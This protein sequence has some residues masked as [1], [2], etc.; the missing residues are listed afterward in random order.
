MTV[1]IIKKTLLTLTILFIVVNVKAQ[2]QKFDEGFIQV[3]KEMQIINPLLFENK[4]VAKPISIVPWKQKE[5]LTI[6]KGRLIK[7]FAYE[8][9]ASI[10]YIYFVFIQNEIGDN[11]IEVYEV[12]YADQKP[13]MVFSFTTKNEDAESWSAYSDNEVIIKDGYLYFESVSTDDSGYYY[14]FKYKLGEKSKV[15]DARYLEGYIDTFYRIDNHTHTA[16]AEA[17]NGELSI[18]SSETDLPEIEFVTKG[19]ENGFYIGNLS[20]SLDDKILYFDNFASGLA[21]IWRYNTESKELSKIVPEHEAEHPFAFTYNYKEYIFYIEENTIKI[22]TSNMK[23]SVPIKTD[24]IGVYE[25]SKIQTLVTNDFEIAEIK[26]SSDRAYTY[27]TGTTQ[28]NSHGT[29]VFSVFLIENMSKI[30]SKI[31][32]EI[33][34]LR[35]YTK[36]RLSNNINIDTIDEAMKIPIGEGDCCYKDNIILFF[37]KKDKLIKGLQIRS[38]HDEE[39][40]YETRKNITPNNLSNQIWIENTVGHTGY[41]DNSKHNYFTNVEKYKFQND[42]L[43]LIS[44]KTIDDYYHVT[45][46][47]GLN[48]HNRPYFSGEK[49]KVLD[50]GAKVKLLNKTD[51]THELWDGSKLVKGNWV[52]IEIDSNNEKFAAYVFDGYLNKEL[53]NVNTN[54]ETTIANGEWRW[55]YDTEQL[56]ELGFYKNGK[57]DG[58]WKWFFKNGTLKAIGSYKDG[59]PNG[60]RKWYYGNNKL[61]CTG[62]FS[63]GGKD[64][65]WIWYSN[66]KPRLSINFDKGNVVEFKI[67]D[68]QEKVILKT[69]NTSASKVAFSESYDYRDVFEVRIENPDDYNLYFGGYYMSFWKSKNNI[70]SGESKSYKNGKLKRITHYKAGLKTGKW[71]HYLG[72][73]ERLHYSEHY[74]NDKRTG[75]HK[76]YHNN[77]QLQFSGKY[78]DGIKVGKWK[79]YY[80][81]G[82]LMSHSYYKDDKYHGKYVDYHEHGKIKEKGSY[83]NGNKEGIWEAYHENGSLKEITPYKNGKIH[84]EWTEYDDDEIL[85]SRTLIK[86]GD[87]K[88]LHKTSFY[89]NGQIRAIGSS[90][91]GLEFGEWKLYYENGQLKEVNHYNEGRKN[92]EWKL[93]YE[94]GQLKSQ[95]QH[96]NGDRDGKFIWYKEDG[97]I[98]GATEY[99][100]NSQYVMGEW[101]YFDN[102]NLESVELY[103]RDE[104]VEWKYY[105]ESGQLKEVRQYYKKRTRTGEWKYYYKSGQLRLLAHYNDEIPQGEFKLYH[106]N[107][108]LYKTQIWEYYKK[109]MKVN[110]CFDAKRNVLNVGTLKNGTGTVNEYNAIGELIN[111]V[112]YIEGKKTENSVSLDDVWNDSNKLNSLAWKAYEEEIDKVKLGLAI[113]WVQHSIELDENYYNTDTYAALLYKISNYKQALNIAKKAI[114]I[115]K[116]TNIKYKATQELMEKINLKLN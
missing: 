64:G 116:K 108:Q 19:F 30:V 100:Y 2:H 70:K 74:K 54:A 28:Y 35:D 80:D 41:E 56:G 22:V 8:A 87:F 24:P 46:K 106:E 95:G 12:D 49:I 52:Q 109:L 68:K 1:D 48:A 51:F 81:N 3:H 29:Q 43:V 13:Y 101:K 112:E 76:Y 58:Q 85:M 114:L 77:G 42:S 63:D 88:N 6:E 115:A 34:G 92:G 110:S 66:D 111:T 75:K 33:L 5:L 32:M 53:V 69:K 61:Y 79:S 62:Q 103:Q 94:S 102:G 97:K 31:S 9:K 93:Y 86:D 71:K 23:A 37:R 14:K 16:S 96:V 90:D 11:S 17:V 82:Q 65:E 36:L 105:Y 91:N 72:D 55:Y 44:P 83:S 98:K 7:V 21:C 39:G 45:A 15:E 25:K 67:F 60:E 104:L 50:F 113:K 59:K 20:W 57:K 107:G 89:P 27:V 78:S 38:S 40:G 4:G 84:G 47:N 18:T 26:R 99:K 73:E 10:F